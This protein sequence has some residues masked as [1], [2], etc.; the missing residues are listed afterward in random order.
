MSKGRSASISLKWV[1][2]TITILFILFAS[3]L[4]HS[5]EI[6]D[7]RAAIQ[8]TAATWEA[9]ENPISMLP[10]GERVR[11]LGVLPGTEPFVAEEIYSAEEAP[12]SIPSKV[13]WRNNGGNYVSSV[14]DQ[15]GCGSC[16]AFA[17]TG[18]L[19]SKAMISLG[20]PGK[21]VN[22]SE[23]IVLSCSSAGSCG[24]GYIN[25]A[26][27]FL[28]STGDGKE[29]CYPYT[30]GNGSCS[31]ACSSWTNRPYRLTSSWAWV[32]RDENSMKTAIANYGPIVVT[33]AVYTDFYYYGGGVYRHTS[34]N[35]EGLHAVLAV[36]YN[37]TG[38]Y[39]IVKNSWGP[40]WGEGG[41]FRI[42]YDEVS[43]QRF[44]WGW[45]GSF[46]SIYP[47]GNGTI[48]YPSGVL[49][50]AVTLTSPNGGEPL[51]SG[52]TFDITWDPPYNPGF[53]DLW[54][55]LNNG[56]T[57]KQFAWDVT[58]TSYPWNVPVLPNNKSTCL[59]GIE[60]YYNNK[61]MSEDISS[62]PFAINVVELTSPN[63]G[64]LVTSGGTWPITWTTNGTTTLVDSVKLTYT[65][66]NGLTWKPIM[67]L[68][69]DP[70]S[71]VWNVPTVKADKTKCK[72]KVVLRDGAGKTVGSDMSDYTFTITNGPT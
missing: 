70:Q 67:T 65:L 21:N 40:Y 32:A 61:K 51:E 18:A 45:C 33:L 30:G 56:L 64:D 27:D 38:R 46:P 7:V 58:G 16:W 71:H 13:D 52:G 66:D 9:A 28:Y 23:Q 62:A 55:S 2:G 24:G 15:G 59:I 54:Y 5:A 14:K 8:A 42:S 47:C 60:D 53:Y 57:W 69:G 17:V 22:L 3:S 29:G 31:R 25:Q 41:Y 12:V 35:I 68:P 19:E 36:G 11:L 6:D 49:P 20:T 26:S 37:D 48:S 39:F 72:V 34:G 1:F 43:A 4:T 50:V 44:G 63:G 10:P